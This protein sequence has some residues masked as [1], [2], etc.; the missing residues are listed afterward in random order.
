MTYPRIGF[1][2]LGLM[3]SAMV[4]RLQ[5]QGHPITVLANQSRTAVE[6]AVARGAVEATR[7]RDQAAPATS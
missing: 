5:A 3:G 1:F 4:E 2:G 7:A 6:A